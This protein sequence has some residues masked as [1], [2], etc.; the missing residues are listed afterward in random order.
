MIKDK[1]EDISLRFKNFFRARPKNFLGIDVGASS[2][3]MIELGRK[4]Q[5]LRLENYG[6]AKLT[7]FNARPIKIFKKNTLSLSNRDIS[8]VI[9]ALLKETGI[10]VKEAAFSIPDFGSFFTGVELPV[11]NKDE[12]SEAVK[13]QARPY[14]PLPLS[15]VTL[16]W[17]IIEGEPS[18][19]A[20][21]VLVVAIPNNI[22]S[23]YQEVAQ[24]SN[25]ELK[26]LEPEVFSLARSSVKGESNKRIIGLIDIGAWSTTCSVLD[27]G[28]LLPKEQTDGDQNIRKVLI[29]LV[30]SILQ[31]VKKALHNFHL[32]EG[33]EVDKIILAGGLS[34]MPGLKEFFSVELKKQIVSADSFLDIAS[35]PILTDVLKEMGPDYS[36]ALG[37]AM[38]GLE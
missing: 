31:E 15:D 34:K 36:I 35:P 27:N 9:K 13:Y 24:L 30:G 19:T 7:D 22:I 3:R 4:G 25:L 38:K 10:Q 14:V 20:I 29:P 23:Y 5:V 8:K 2:I 26:F 28:V 6:E 1:L 18:K 16:D 11:M 21:K 37:L 32:Q 17:S 12:I 33:K